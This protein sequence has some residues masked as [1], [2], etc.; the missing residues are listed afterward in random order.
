MNVPKY[1]D[2]N[3]RR[4]AAANA[5]KALVEKF[6]ARPGPDD[7]AVIARQEELKAIAEARDARNAERAAAKAAEVERK[8]LEA[9]AAA[10]AEAARQAEAE[11]RAKDAAVR[12]AEEIA[13]AIQ[14]DQDA[15]TRAQ[16][17]AAEQKAIRD[18]RY[19]A[20]KARGSKR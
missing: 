12:R 5:K 9:V 3:E 11:A 1:Q 13:R 19:A 14:L 18:A 8:R 10:A 20:R 16:A 7:P 17:L 15:K 2:F 4:V 6:K